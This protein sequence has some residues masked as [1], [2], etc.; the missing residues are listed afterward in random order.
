[1]HARNCALVLALHAAPAACLLHGT[2]GSLTQNRAVMA[3]SALQHHVPAARASRGTVAVMV[4]DRGSNPLAELPLPSIYA[5]AYFFIGFLTLRDLTFNAKI[6]G[7]WESG[8]AIADTP[9]SSFSGAAI[10]VSFAL[11]N[12]AKFA[13]V[14]KTDYYDDL[15]G[16]ELN[17]LSAQGRGPEPERCL[18]TSRW[19]GPS[20]R[21][22]HLQAAASGAPSFTSS[23][24]PA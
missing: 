17:S 19:R 24:F 11:L 20:T 14:G 5:I 15:E 9:W 3:S 8:H 6:L 12:L 22:R 21:S 16:L 23:A 2:H 1:M 18:A 7:W 13:G 10:L 4:E